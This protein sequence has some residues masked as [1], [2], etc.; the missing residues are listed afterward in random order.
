MLV[1][2]DDVMAAIT[3]TPSRRMMAVRRIFSAA[4]HDALS[5]RLDSA[6]GKKSVGPRG[7]VADKVGLA[8]GAVLELLPKVDP[9]WGAELDAV[10]VGSTLQ[11]TAWDE[12]GEGEATEPGT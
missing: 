10:V 6:G 11:H 1:A 2:C 8:I 12:R 3:G 7:A 4:S 5:P 9:V